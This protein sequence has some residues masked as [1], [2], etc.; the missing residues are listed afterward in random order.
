MTKDAAYGLRR[1]ARGLHP[2]RDLW[3]HAGL[4]AHLAW[5]QAKLDSDAR[6]SKVP[7]RRPKLQATPVSSTSAPAATGDRGSAR[8]A[9]ERAMARDVAPPPPPAPEPR[10]QSAAQR[11]M[12]ALIERRRASWASTAPSEG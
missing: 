12:Q 3:V 5:L 9:V 6:H 2:H 11:R 10:P 4:A 7:V 1:V 8:G